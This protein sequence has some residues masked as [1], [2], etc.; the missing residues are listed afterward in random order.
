M[1]VPK[2][3]MS[4]ANTRSRRANWKTSAVATNTCPQCGA[5]KQ[6]HKA[7]PACGVYNGRHYEAAEQ[8]SHQD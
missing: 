8:T 4:R 2:R 6:P 1:A 3:K 7:C 5:Q